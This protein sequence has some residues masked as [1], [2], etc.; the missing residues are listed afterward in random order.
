MAE[1]LSTKNQ[2]VEEAYSISIFWREYFRVFEQLIV[3]KEKH[4][5][6][7]VL[8]REMNMLKTIEYFNNSVINVVQDYVDERAIGWDGAKK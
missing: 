4:S 5:L 6:E 8:E 2:R 3:E 7:T 1:L